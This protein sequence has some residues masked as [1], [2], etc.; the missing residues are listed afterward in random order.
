MHNSTDIKKTVSI[1][2]ILLRTFRFLRPRESDASITTTV[3]CFCSTCTQHDSHLFVITVFRKLQ[4]QWRCFLQKILCNA[5]KRRSFVLA[6]N[7]GTNFSHSSV[8][9]QIFTENSMCRILLTQ[10]LLQSPALSNDVLPSPN[11][12]GN[13]ST[14]AALREVWGL[15]QRCSL[16]C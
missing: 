4:D 1:T 7:L 3:F 15:P 2:L 11:F 9:I 8:H 10:T 5:Q 14:V 16:F 6:S 12:A 13:S